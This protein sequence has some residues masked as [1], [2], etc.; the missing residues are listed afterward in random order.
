VWP[1]GWDNWKLPERDKTARYAEFGSTGPGANA[2]ARVKWAHQL[3]TDEAAA[4]TPE[5]VLAGADGWN[6]TA[7]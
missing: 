1:A 4:I 7:K 3:S 5:K 6:P 2:D